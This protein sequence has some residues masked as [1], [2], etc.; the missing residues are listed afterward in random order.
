MP[1]NRQMD[2]EDVVSLTRPHTHN[3]IL[4]SQNE[5]LPFATTRTNLEII[6]NETVT[7]RQIVY[8]FTY[9]NNLKKQKGTT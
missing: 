6:L 8:D 3:G 5:I 2:K 7:E 9:M 1:I 4:F